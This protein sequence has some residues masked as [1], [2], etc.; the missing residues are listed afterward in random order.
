MD[1]SLDPY[2]IVVLDKEIGWCRLFRVGSDNCPTGAKPLWEGYNLEIGYEEMK[3]HNRERKPVPSYFISERANENGKMIF[4][5]F[6]ESPTSPWLEKELLHDYEKAKSRVKELCLERDAVLIEATERK[7][8]LMQRLGITAK[9]LR[10]DERGKKYI[11]WLTEAGRLG[12]GDLDNL[13][14]LEEN[15]F[16]SLSVP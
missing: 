16:V 11:A 6:K 13:R 7:K 4:R 12:E 5:I 15:G 8:S 10:L 14:W 3:L 9:T 2:Y 1:Q